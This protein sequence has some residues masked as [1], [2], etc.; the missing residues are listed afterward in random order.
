MSVHHADDEIT[1]RVRQHHIDRLVCFDIQIGVDRQDVDWE[2]DIGVIHSARYGHN[3]DPRVVFRRAFGGGTTT[4]LK[5]DVNRLVGMSRQVSIDYQL[6]NIATGVFKVGQ[7]CRAE[8]D[9]RV[10]QSATL[11]RL[12][13]EPPRADTRGGVLCLVAGGA[14]AEVTSPGG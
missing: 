3:V 12:Q 14:L 10:Q 2:S 8:F 4:T 11:E 9:R 13:Y 7:R 6:R 1:G 5:L